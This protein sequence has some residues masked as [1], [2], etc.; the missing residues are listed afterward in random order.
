MAKPF[1]IGVYLQSLL[2]LCL[3]G[4]TALAQ[5]PKTPPTGNTAATTFFETNVRPLL[6]E[7]CF[8]CHGDKQ[9]QGGLRLDTAEGLHKGAVSG[10]VVIAGNSDKSTLI[11]VIR[12]Q[13]NVKMPPAGKLPDAQIAALT[14]WVKQGAVWPTST[15]TPAI[16]DKTKWERARQFWSFRPVKKSVPPAVKNAA[17]VKTPIDAFIL[18]KLEAKGLKPAPPADKR[19]LIR[20]ATFD[21][22]GLPPTPEEIK[23][24]LDDKSPNAFAKVVDRLLASPRY[25]ERY[26]RRWLD[27]VRYADSADARGL[28][29]EGDISEALALPGLGG[30]RHQPG[31]ALQRV[32]QEPDRGRPAEVGF[33]HQYPRHYRHRYA[34]HRQ[35]GQ[36]R[37]R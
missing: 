9:Q 18:A 31:H 16:D 2:L 32:H 14:E 26:G 24:F 12:Y 1:P 27:V 35:L 7:K 37:R 21:L 28:G 33:R 19:T 6:F 30:E 23:A 3:C 8:T 5:Q 25:G 22:S 29:S 4:P 15:A 36:R 13:G 34:R 11:Q 17:W 10:P 20:R